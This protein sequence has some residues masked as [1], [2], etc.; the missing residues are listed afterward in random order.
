MHDNLCLAALHPKE[1][2]AA[3]TRDRLGRTVQ[4]LSRQYSHP[5]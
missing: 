4:E 5:A 3:D 1:D 2:L